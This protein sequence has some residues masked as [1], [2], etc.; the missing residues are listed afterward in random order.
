MDAAAFVPSRGLTLVAARCCV[1]DHDNAA[2]LGVGVDFEYRTSDDSFLAVQCK[3]CGVVYLNPRPAE[4]EL[5]RIY[6]DTY[7]AFQFDAE[8]F[9][10]VYAVRRRLEARRL[11]RVGG[12]LPPDARILDVGCGDGFHLALLRDFGPRGWRLEGLD[13]DERAARAAEKKGLTV[14]R[15]RLE[16]GTLP[17][18]S[19]D[20]VLMIQTIEHLP[21]PAGALASARRLLVPGGRLFVVTDNTDSFDFGLAKSRHWGGYHFPRHFYLF[22]ARAMRMLAARV[23]LEVERLTTAVSPVNWVYTIR[24]ALDDVGAP[25]PVVNAFSLRSTPALAAFTALD[26][27]N[28][29][30]GRGALLHVLLR[31]PE[32][33]AGGAA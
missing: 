27:V 23:G 3:T 21:D 31:R 29:L 8:R 6:P 26:T 14:H 11:L 33:D 10:L 25:A 15:A 19:Y 5:R 4:S 13:A 28:N 20:L 18:A 32:S 7:H 24:N 1:C 22:N 16:D 17:E 9:G 30:F 12:A 2:P